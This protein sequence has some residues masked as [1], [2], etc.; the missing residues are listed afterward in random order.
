MNV[1]LT[2]PMV[3]IE[4]DLFYHVLVTKNNYKTILII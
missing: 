1:I 2:K 4:S 3:V